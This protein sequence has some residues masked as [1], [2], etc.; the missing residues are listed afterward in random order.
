MQ[1]HSLV[2][3]LSHGWGLQGAVLQAGRLKGW[4]PGPHGDTP[5]GDMT[6]STLPWTHHTL[7]ARHSSPTLTFPM[8]RL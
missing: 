3:V 5:R 4:L 7:H 1:R 2:W 6:I 8:R